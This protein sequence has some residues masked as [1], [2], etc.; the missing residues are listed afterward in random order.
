MFAACALVLVGW[1]AIRRVYYIGRRCWIRGCLNRG[2]AVGFQA[3]SGPSS[4]LTSGP[5]MCGP[6]PTCWVQPCAGWGATSGPSH[7]RAGASRTIGHARAVERHRADGKVCTRYWM[8]LTSH[9]TRV[10]SVRTCKGWRVP[11]RCGWASLLPRRKN[12]PAQQQRASTVRY[13]LA[14]PALARAGQ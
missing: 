11:G 6:A 8:Q 3:V 13:W 1:I 7:V 12:R 2:A 5:A 10:S 4:L 9:I 14:T